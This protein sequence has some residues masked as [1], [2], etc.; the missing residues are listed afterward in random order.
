VATTIDDGDYLKIPSR[1]EKQL[2]AALDLRGIQYVRDDAL[3]VNISLQW[4]VVG[5]APES[6]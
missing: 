2:Q 5:D 6:Y 1:Y 4:R 3:I